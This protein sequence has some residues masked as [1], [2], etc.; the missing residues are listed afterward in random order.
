ML[1]QCWLV[2]LKES[3][4]HLLFLCVLNAVTRHFPAS[5]VDGDCVLRGEKRGSCQVLLHLSNLS[6]LASLI[7]GS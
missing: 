4:S 2:L 1:Q 3:W 7:L 6:C 5:L